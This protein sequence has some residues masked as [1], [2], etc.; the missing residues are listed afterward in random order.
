MGR[1]FNPGTLM[2]GLPRDQYQ[3]A[4]SLDQNINGSLDLGRVDAG[5]KGAIDSTG[6]PAAF[7]KGNGSGILIRIGASGSTNGPIYNW[8][9]SNTGIAVNHQLQRQPIGFHLV[10]SDKA[11]QVYRVGTANTNTITLAPSD[12]TANATVYIF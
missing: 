2:Q 4:Q 5:A 12:A 3:W 8:T 1:T 11:L 10:D 6:T 9:T 7:T